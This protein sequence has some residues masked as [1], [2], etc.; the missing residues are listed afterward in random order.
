MIHVF[1][2]YIFIHIVLFNFFLFILFFYSTVSPPLGD[3]LVVR[4]DISDPFN[5]S[6]PVTKHGG[7]LILS[8][9]N[10]KLGITI[11]YEAKP[12]KK[13]KEKG[14]EV[15]KGEGEGEGVHLVEVLFASPGKYLGMVYFNDHPVQSCH[16]NIRVVKGRGAGYIVKGGITKTRHKKKEGKEKEPAF[17]PRIF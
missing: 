9:T 7:Q 11:E 14:K 15:K 6:R 5:L 10:V 13:K 3:T 16:A 4:I 17:N 1:Y 8:I 2:S 12:M